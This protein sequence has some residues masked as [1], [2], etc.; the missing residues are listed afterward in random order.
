MKICWKILEHEKLTNSCK[1][2]IA[3]LKEQHW[4]YGIQSQLEWMYKNICSKDLHLIGETRDGKNGYICAYLNMVHLNIWFDEKLID[5]IG[6]GN[7]CVN[8]KYEHLGYGIKLLEQVNKYLRGS[9]KQGILLCRDLLV[10][11]YKKCDWKVLSSKHVII[12]TSKYTHKVM[13]YPE[14]KREV[15]KIKIEKNF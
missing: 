13:M 9:E 12:G 7:V 15:N 1:E 6:I 3:K 10:R 2:Q 8:K 11:F 5:C 14:I 4:E